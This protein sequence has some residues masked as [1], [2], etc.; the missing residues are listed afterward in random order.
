MRLMSRDAV[1]ELRASVGGPVHARGDVGFAEAVGGF[2]TLSP[3]NP[4]LV[5]VAGSEADVQAGVRWAVAHGTTVHPLATGHGAYRRLDHGLLLRTSRLDRIA[6]DPES[7]I[8]TAGAGLPWSG[9]LPHLHAAGLGAVTGSAKTVGAVGLT[10]GGGIGP[11]G[12]TFGMAADWVRGYRVVDANGD[13][14]VVGPDSY[15]DLFWALRGGKVGLGVVTE[16]TVQA[17]PMP[18]VY[19]GG[20][21]YPEAEIGR[22]AHAWLDW[23]QELPESV[24]TS[25][26]IFRLPP[27]LPAP[28][29]GRTWFHF[30]Y[31]YAELGATNE[32]LRERGEEHLAAWRAIAGPGEVDMI[33]LLPSDRVGEIHQEPEGPVPLW[34]YGDFLRTIDHDFIDVVLRHVGGGVESPLANVEIRFHGGAYAREPELPSAIGGR[35]EPFTILVLAHPD[36]ASRPWE[37]VEAAGYAIRD[38]VVPWRGAEVN[39]NWANHPSKETFQ[40]RLWAPEVRERLQAIRAKYDPHGVFEFGN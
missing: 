9:I 30:R 8:W 19:A 13:V 31:G 4:D 37:A 25:I 6:V 40:T 32:Q 18:F 5:L 24:N 36:D 17:L 1:E 20:V 12:R 11:F 21:Y 26:A 15:P 2:N 23:I 16:M 7:G 34:E 35:R 22:L 38:A 14:L 29:G 39:Y 3:T 28:L 27:E 33:G 10:M